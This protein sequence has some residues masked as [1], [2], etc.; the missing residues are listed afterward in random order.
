LSKLILHIGPHKTGTTYIQHMMVEN[1]TRFPKTMQI[2]RKSDPLFYSLVRVCVLQAKGEEDTTELISKLATELSQ[3]VTKDYALASDEDILGPLPS[4]FIYN[5][6]YG[7]AATFLPIIQSAVR[8]T[9]N[10]IH[11]V[12][13]IRRFHDWLHS[14]YRYTFAD[15]PDRPFAPKK[16]KQKRAL[17]DNWL[18]VR[19][20]LQDS[21]GTDGISFV[22]YE[23]DRATG[24]LGTALFKMCGLTDAELDTLNWI[25]PVNVAQPKT[26]DPNHW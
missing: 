2:I 12:F 3:F 1:R 10:D 6:L 16:Y 24:R 8:A 22:N 4:R 17:P 18:T 9:G 20:S 11:F 19:Q 7:Q 15:T 26:I 21:L 23:S 14:L 5:P 25:E 13:Y